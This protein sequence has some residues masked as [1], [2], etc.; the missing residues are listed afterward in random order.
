VNKE[1]TFDE[2][3][4]SDGGMGPFN[5]RIDKEGQQL[6]NEDDDGVG[7][8][9]EKGIDDERGVGVDTDAGDMDDMNVAVADEVHVPID[10]ETLN[11]MNLVQLR[12][13][14]KLWQQSVSGPKLILKK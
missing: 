11:K 6:F 5:N 14:L 4:D 13:E 10:S 7:F 9:A 3:Y 8:V 2:G 12:N 1:D